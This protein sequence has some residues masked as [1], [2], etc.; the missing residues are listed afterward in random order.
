MF[1]WLLICL[2]LPALIFM[3]WLVV[4]IGLWIEDGFFK[5]T[6]KLF[7]QYGMDAEGII[8]E[9]EEYTGPESRSSDPCFK[10]KYQYTDHQGKTHHHKFKNHCFDQW[11]IAREPGFVVLRETYQPGSTIKVRYLRTFPRI[12]Y[13]TIQRLTDAKG[14]E[15]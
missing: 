15:H 6:G 10:G 4:R 13:T 3:L 7:Q 1:P 12:H 8:L 9:S 14:P 5:V 11:D 2:H